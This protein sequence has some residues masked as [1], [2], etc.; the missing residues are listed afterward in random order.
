MI[1]KVNKVTCVFCKI[2]QKSK[3]A[4]LL[5]D[6]SLT[7]KSIESNKTIENLNNEMNNLATIIHDLRKQ[8]L[9]MQK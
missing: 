7:E 6:S 4:N 5:M 8:Y 3:N 1:Y 2:S 9:N